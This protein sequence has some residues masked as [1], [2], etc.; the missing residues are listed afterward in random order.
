[1]IQPVS[2]R[3]IM[4]IQDPVLNKEDANQMELGVDKTLLAKVCNAYCNKDLS[5]DYS[6]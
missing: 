6:S 2:S 1:M 5:N 3:A 4:A